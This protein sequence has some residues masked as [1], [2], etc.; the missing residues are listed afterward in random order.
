[1]YLDHFGFHAPPFA[2]TPDT[3][4]FFS[5]GE[6]GE[7]LE[8][9]LKAVEA[10]EGFVK[11]VGEVGSG[12]TMLCR[13]F[14]RKLPKNAHLAL[15]LNPGIPPEE[16]TSALMGE[17]RLSPMR[18]EGAA[19]RHQAL[20]EFFVSLERQGKRAVIVVEEA[21]SMPPA[22][23]E[24]LRLISNLETER[25]KLVSIVL[26]GQPELDR[27][28]QAR[29]SRQILERITTQ[30][31]LP[32]LSVEQTEQYLRGRLHASGY[33]GPQLFSTGAVRA[34]HRSARGSF[35]QINLLAE[36]SIVHASRGGAH[37][38]Q[39]RHVAQGISSLSGH[40]NSPAW[41]RPA[42]AAG[43]M[44]ALLAGGLALQSSWGINLSP[45]ER[46]LSTLQSDANQADISPVSLPVAGQTNQAATDSKAAIPT[47]VN[48]FRASKGKITPVAA[49]PP[50]SV[51]APHVAGIAS[52]PPRSREPVNAETETKR[53]TATPPS[54]PESHHAKATPNLDAPSGATSPPSV[55]GETG[56]TLAKIAPPAQVMANALTVS[57]EPIEM[58]P[59]PLTLARTLRLPTPPMPASMV[60]PVKPTF[61]R[62]ATPT[63]KAEVREV[64]SLPGMQP[65]DPMRDRVRAAYRWLETSHN[66]R[67]TIQLVQLRNIEG[68]GKVEKS[69]AAAR[70]DLNMSELKIFRLRNQKLLVYLGDFDSEHEAQEALL[71]LPHELLTGGPMVVPIERVKTFVRDRTRPEGCATGQE[72]RP[73][74]PAA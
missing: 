27:K 70:S 66:T 54:T 28:L 41:R 19:A 42:L 45:Y 65:T 5:G 57:Y 43:A 39:S 18:E 40:P 3:E 9:L 51:Q 11:V 24:A 6:R 35:R 60:Q 48:D 67:H 20:L 61:A 59:T 7:I 34:I 26:F 37:Q 55:P 32:K 56:N 22:T 44:I 52:N 69:L 63:R 38:I 50:P 23:L 13:L 46:I 74:A 4:L 2:I 47:D 58:G 10:G 17:F 73:C 30:L 68:I 12:K 53:P 72:G 33:R 16:L 14:C 49:T 21:Q 31:T 64:A 8:K 15:L 1:M 62:V 25:V 29:D 71:R 36:K